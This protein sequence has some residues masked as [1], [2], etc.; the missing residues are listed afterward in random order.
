MLTLFLNDLRRSFLAAS[1]GSLYLVPNVS[2]GGVADEVIRL[3][4]VVILPSSQ[5]YIQE[6]GVADLGTEL[7]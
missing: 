6:N 1:W 3:T 7:C 5:I 4:E 2:S